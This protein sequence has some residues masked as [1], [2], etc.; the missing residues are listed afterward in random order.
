MEEEGGR[1]LLGSSAL[2]AERTAA[3]E[4]APH[5]YPPLSNS[6]LKPRYPAFGALGVKAGH[7]GPPR[8]GGPGRVCRGSSAFAE[9]CQQPHSRPPGER[10][11]GRGL[12]CPLRGP[13][14]DTSGPGAALGGKRDAYPRRARPMRWSSGEKCK[15]DG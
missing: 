4:P 3:G 8:P 6:P 2:R 7:S 1:P 9:G 10:R 14:G 15:T 13:G 12:S 5:R 11:L